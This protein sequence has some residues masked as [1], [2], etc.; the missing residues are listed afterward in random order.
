MKYVFRPRRKVAS[1]I[2]T[3]AKRSLS[4]VPMARG[5]A[6]YEI[7]TTTGWMTAEEIVR[8][9]EF[10][11]ADRQLAARLVKMH[12]ESPRLARL[13]ASHRKWLMTQAMYALCM[14]RVP[15]RDASGLNATRFIEVVTS[16]GVASRNTAD[17]FLKELLAY[18]FLQEVPSRHDKRIHILDST[19]LSDRAMIGWFVGQMTELDR[20]DGG[21]RV[22]ACV[23]NPIIFRRAQP[24]AIEALIANPAW[25][26][27]PDSISHFLSS[28]LGGMIIHEF[29][30]A[31]ADIAPID[32]R[33]VVG[34]ANI[35]SL[36][37]QYGISA[38]NIKRMLKRAQEGGVLGWDGA[39]GRKILWLSQ[40]FLD[41]YTWWQAQKF[42]ALD[43]AF[44]FCVAT[45][46][47]AT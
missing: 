46:S 19:P 39:H 43:E 8:H 28:E 1:T 32:D 2:A 33:I 31:I 23:Q 12:R 9:P 26:Y 11:S 45:A 17:A 34:P 25:R 41:D 21:S 44:H 20:M 4:F 42:A 5:A 47:R 22:D 18:K 38:T 29:M 3:I 14:Q 36:A 27:P 15:G 35:L 6:E 10:P 40:R 30:L 13:K 24:R 37:E 7:G 16:I